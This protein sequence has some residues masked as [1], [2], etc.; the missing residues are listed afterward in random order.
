MKI[1]DASTINQELGDSILPYDLI[2]I[3]IFTYIDKNNIKD[4]I[5][6]CKYVSDATTHML[7]ENSNYID[8]WYIADFTR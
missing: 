6:G 3:P 2:S 1:R 4:D 5:M 8:Y 7:N